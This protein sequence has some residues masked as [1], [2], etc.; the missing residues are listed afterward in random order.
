MKVV[1]DNSDED[2]ARHR[3]E[4]E[5]I[6]ALKE[7]TANLMRITRGAGAAERLQSQLIAATKSLIAYHDSGGW[8][9]GSN[10]LQIAMDVE[11]SGDILDR[12]DARNRQW[13]R[14]EDTIIKGSLQMAASR[15][16][17]Q[18]TQQRAGETE[19]FNGLCVIEKQREENRLAAHA[20]TPRTVKSRRK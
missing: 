17:G 5:M 6:W 12:C 3:I 9:G 2:V 16:L 1:S 4:G 15:L 10:I 18:S 14:A 19:M 7:L 20:R 8:V 13:A 11:T